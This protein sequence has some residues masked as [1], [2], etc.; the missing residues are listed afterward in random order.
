MLSHFSCLFEK[1]LFIWLCHVLVAALGDL[2]HTLGV[3][4]LNHWT[5]REVPIFH[6]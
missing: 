6:I 5:T 3:W 4:A 2:V 1:S